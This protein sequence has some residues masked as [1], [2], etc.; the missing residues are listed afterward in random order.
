MQ[1]VVAVVVWRKY[2]LQYTTA[3]TTIL[4]AVHTLKQQHSEYVQWPW[5]ISCFEHVRTEL[6][7]ARCG[8]AAAGTL[9]I[10]ITTVSWK[11]ASLTWRA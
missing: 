7:R 5:S 4:V 2:V 1:V 3:S 11:G 8:L 9:P 6:L 10:V